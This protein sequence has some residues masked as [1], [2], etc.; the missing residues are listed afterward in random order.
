MPRRF[1]I[2]EA[3]KLMHPSA[4][5]AAEGHNRRLK[6]PS[7]ADPSRAHLNVDLLPEL[8]HLN[9]NDRVER[10]LAPLGIRHHKREVLAIEI[11]LGM[12]KEAQAH[13]PLDQWQVKA[14]AAAQEIAGPGNLI[15]ADAHYDETTP[16]LHAIF[17][18][19]IEVDRKQR[20]PLPKSGYRKQRK[21]HV[22]SFAAFAGRNRF[23]VSKTVTGWHDI[24]AKHTHSVGLV[25]G[26]PGG[27]IKQIPQRELYAETAEVEAM[28]Q[29][30]FALLK[31][32]N[33][34]LAGVRRPTQAELADDGKWRVYRELVTGNVT[35]VLQ[36]AAAG[37]PELLELA[38]GGL[39]AQR[40]QEKL[41]QI[42]EQRNAWKER[43]EAS[44]RARS[45][46]SVSH[47]AEVRALEQRLQAAEA[48]PLSAR[49]IAGILGL[50]MH[51]RQGRDG[52]KLDQVV[53]AAGE[54]L[55]LQ[56]GIFVRPDGGKL[57]VVRFLQTEL[58][59]GS[60]QEVYAL[61]AERVGQAKA[62]ATFA[63]T[64]QQAYAGR[65]PAG[66]HGLPGPTAHARQLA[67]Q[68]ELETHLNISPQTTGRL[69]ERGLLTVN[70]RGEGVLLPRDGDL[71]YRFAVGKDGCVSRS[72]PADF[73]PVSLGF[74]GTY[75]QLITEDIGLSL[76]AL[77][78][79]QGNIVCDLVSP[80]VL[81]EAR[82]NALKG[83]HRETLVTPGA[84]SP[85]W[86]PSMS[87]LIRPV[88][89]MLPLVTEIMRAA[90][91]PV[92]A[93]PM[94]ERK[95]VEMDWQ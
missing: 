37:L 93:E 87:A 71:G 70:G 23:E 78:A 27:R 21:I 72:V 16:H 64:V 46:L 28:A 2:L 52:R 89:E 12:S 47:R 33:A 34:L 56:G 41:R 35:R 74:A 79:T 49:D 29:A 31:N 82:L 75:T 32:P 92:F 57:S 10:R 7:N 8:Q 53:N 24:Y 38:K 91:H 25:R 88:G 60:P 73:A 85:G 65:P 15:S 40:A 54:R 95:R 3:T 94:D 51:T 50:P 63:A 81:S 13:V 4:L 6:P 18:P 90:K 67:L 44:D 69:F 77:D 30:L 19:V 36:K 43:A 11:V 42:D 62:L 83:Q 68:A 26:T 48:A 59:L 14:W 17:L 86:D 22:L 1:A 45:D 61:L 58:Q 9:F 55:T 39:F 20:G 80:C 5:A 84:F 76:Q 66:S